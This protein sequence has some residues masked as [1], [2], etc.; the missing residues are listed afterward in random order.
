[1]GKIR[2]AAESVEKK[3]FD[4]EKTLVT[5][6][7]DAGTL[8]NESL[9]LIQEGT[10]P[11]DRIGRK[12]TITNILIRGNALLN[13]TTAAGDAHDSVRIILVLDRQANGTALTNMNSILTNGGAE[14]GTFQFNDLNFVRRFKI[15]WDKTITMNVSGAGL[16]ATD[17][18]SATHRDFHYYKKVKIS[19]FFD[20][21]AAAMANV[22]SN[23][24]V[25]LAVSTHGLAAI[26][27]SWRL[28]FVG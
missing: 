8:L 22:E 6:A 21:A 3:F 27:Y 18:W 9:N 20:L 7:Q 4:G 13:A 17:S 14:H 19:L 24:L 1:M 15:L 5:V 28:R 25:M 16:S 26:R 2:L 11:F 23:N 10:E 12:C